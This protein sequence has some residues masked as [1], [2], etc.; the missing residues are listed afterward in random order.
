MSFLIFCLEDLSIFDSGVLKTPTIIV[1]LSISIL[2]SSKIFSIFGCSYVGC[3][4]IYNVYLF[5]V[6]SSFEYYEVNF[7]VS[8]YGPSFEVYFVWL[9]VLLPLLFFP[10]HLIGKIVSST[11][12][13]VCVGL[14]S[15]GGSLLGSICVGHV[16]LS[17][18]YSMAFDWSF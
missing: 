9:W 4:Y 14:L 5:L 10:V 7:W 18:S 6:D 2:K 17:F 3:I 13:S 16:F 8:L 12:L 1:L 15:W 11:S